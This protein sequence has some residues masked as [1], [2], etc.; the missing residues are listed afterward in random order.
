[1][2]AGIA[3]LAAAVLLVVGRE[4]VARALTHAS[5]AREK[6]VASFAGG[7]SLAF[8]LLEL[9]VELAEGTGHDLHHV[10]RAGPEPVHT[11]ALLILAGTI[12]VFAAH[13]Y[14][15]RH[16]ESWRSYT[17]AATPQALYGALVG[18]AIDAEVHESWRGSAVLWLAML[19]HLGVADYRLAIR[20]PREHRGVGRFLVVGAPLAG[21]AVWIL[22]APTHGTFQLV[23]A[24]VAGATI[25][26]IFREELPRASE[27]RMDAFLAGIVVFGGL[28]QARWW[29]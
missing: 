29:L 7:V 27:V 8:V 5:N 13:V 25:L 15:S 16:D 19:L 20:F 24:L 23:L 10:I 21:E 22:A 18:A 6:L 28:V 17:V 2:I 9:F 26:S 4:L 12:V 1:M 11:T 3:A 14:D